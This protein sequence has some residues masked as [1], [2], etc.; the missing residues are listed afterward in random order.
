MVK[1]AV[2]GGSESW[3]YSG[4]CEW[5]ARGFA[6]MGTTNWTADESKFWRI[7][8][9]ANAAGLCMQQWRS[10]LP[11]RPI[12]CNNGP[13]NWVTPPY[14][15]GLGGPYPGLGPSDPSI[16][17]LTTGFTKFADFWPSG[18][19]LPPNRL[20]GQSWA[21]APWQGGITADHYPNMGTVEYVIFGK[22]YMLENVRE[23]A[24]HNL[25]GNNAISGNPTMSGGGL[26]LTQWPNTNGNITLY[27]KMYQ[28]GQPRSDMG[29][30]PVV[31]ASVLGSPAPELAYFQ[32]FVEAMYQFFDFLYN[33]WWFQGNDDINPGI[34]T[35][36]WLWTPWFAPWQASYGAMTYAWSRGMTR[37]PK[38]GIICNHIANYYA[39]LWG[40]YS[41]LPLYF[42][43]PYF[44]HHGT[45]NVRPDMLATA[46]L[47]TVGQGTRFGKSTEWYSQYSPGITLDNAG[48]VT[49]THARSGPGSTGMPFKQDGVTL[50]LTNGDLVV[51]SNL[52]DAG[53][54]PNDYSGPPEYDPNTIYYI[55]QLHVNGQD[56]F[57][58][59]S[60]LNDPGG[61][62]AI[63]STTPFGDLWLGYKPIGYDPPPGGTSAGEYNTAPQGTYSYMRGAMRHNDT[64][65]L[66]LTNP[67]F[68]W[69]KALAGIEAWNL[70]D[71]KPLRSGVLTAFKWDMDNS[72]KVV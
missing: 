61:A 1:M 28:D 7:S 55:C 59:T 44:F 10:N 23:L 4:L 39:N 2:G 8:H 13:A 22:R 31:S 12:V 50:P 47:G 43:A 32:D 51:M 11:R 20:T 68:D 53:I 34:K 19:A 65:P 16:N 35:C 58:L 72:V 54:F 63:T 64:M 21:W 24:A 46:P 70:V 67:A 33:L 6:R 3:E 69:A 29:I 5:D 25:I 14:H 62:H 26:H 27:S 49:V 40:G 56:T 15:N 45:L 60:T 17:V 71:Y 42:C 37:H 36:S 18:W 52:S 48:V 57:R 66:T 9:A 41:G 30:L 38:A